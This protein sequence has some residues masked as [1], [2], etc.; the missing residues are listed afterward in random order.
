MCLPV[1][2]CLLTLV[3][4]VSIPN[5]Q[6]AVRFDFIKRLSVKKIRFMEPIFNVLSSNL[7]G[8]DFISGPDALINHTH[9]N[10][11]GLVAI[12]NVYKRQVGY[13]NILFWEFNQ[14]MNMRPIVCG[15]QS[16]LFTNVERES[17]FIK[18]LLGFRLLPFGN[19]FNTQEIGPAD[20]HSSYSGTIVRNM[21][22]NGGFSHSWQREDGYP[23][24][25]LPLNYLICTLHLT[26]LAADSAPLVKTSHGNGDGC[27]GS[28][29]AR[30]A[31][32]WFDSFLPCR[33]NPL[34]RDIE[35]AFSCLLIFI[36]CVGC[37]AGGRC[38][39]SMAISPQDCVFSLLVSL[40]S[41]PLG[42]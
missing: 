24:T 28:P 42:G 35:I 15:R 6:L 2:A 9:R 17:P 26:Q 14:T 39:F 41:W 4:G 8:C 3:V 40:L 38:V 10:V 36:G 11:A 22:S 1:L 13:G 12:R 30:T 32:D 27:K 25:V 34:A 16:C 33:M 29:K 18:F 20:D 5:G 37:G 19:L 21:Q 31:S 7:I 23:R